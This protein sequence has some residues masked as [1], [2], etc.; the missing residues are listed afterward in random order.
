MS[1]SRIVCTDL[2]KAYDGRPV[3]DGFSGQIAAGEAVA[4]LARVVPAKARC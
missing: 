3:L 4:V 1:G 2:S